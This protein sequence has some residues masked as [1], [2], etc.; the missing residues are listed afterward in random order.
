MKQAVYKIIYNDHINFLLRNINKALLALLPIKIKIPPSG[1]LK[2]RNDEGRT[3][4]ICTNQTNYLTRLLFWEGGYKKFEYSDIFIKLIKKMDC[5]YD[6]GAS[7]GY[8]S[9]LAAMEHPYMRVVGFEP[10]RGPLFYF[11]KNVAIND[12]QNIRIEPL[13]LSNK[14]GEATFFEITNKKYKY[15]EH[16]LAGENGLGGKVKERSTISRKVK[17]TT[18]DDFVKKNKETNIDL[19]KIDTEGTEDLILEKSTYVLSHFKPIIIC[20]T[21]FDTI[22]PALEKVIRP[23]GYEF[24]NHTATG[25]QK[26]SSIE[27][28]EDNGIRNCFFVHPSKRHLVEEFIGHESG[29]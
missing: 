4:K 3:L 8:Y 11:K 6:I 14:E 21:L 1:I 19:I 10:A 25:L 12:F 28:T 13:A 29:S 7:I 5:F 9:L 26:V 15:L 24:Y 27:R 2:I 20:E 23:F 16:N 22:E 18:L 17:T